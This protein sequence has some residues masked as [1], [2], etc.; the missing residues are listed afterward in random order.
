MLKES[1]SPNIKMRFLIMISLAGFLDYR[2]L[3]TNC[4]I[5]H[6]AF[7]IGRDEIKSGAQLIILF[8]YLQNP[9]PDVR[10]DAHP[11]MGG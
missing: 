3:R 10:V 2:A 8:Q 1:W 4:D 11:D 9:F 5:F 6:A 7:P